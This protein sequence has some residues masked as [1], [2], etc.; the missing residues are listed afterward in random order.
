ME[1]HSNQ[2]KAPGFVLFNIVTPPQQQ[3][4]LYQPP[5]LF[6]L[7]G[8]P[9]PVIVN[10][11]IRSMGPVDETRQAFSLDC[12]FRQT[13]V[14]PR[15][16]Y[17]ATGEASS[18]RTKAVDA[19]SAELLPPALFCSPSLQIASTRWVRSSFSTHCPLSS[20]QRQ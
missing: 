15:L 16:R 18:C 5:Q 8:P 17:N 14:D 10:L 2:P 11:S 13:W 9:I 4:F 7:G 19:L 20:N 12:Y 3:L 6:Q 1:L